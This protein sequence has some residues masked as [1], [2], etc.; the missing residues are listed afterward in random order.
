M[1]PPLQFD[2]L[3]PHPYLAQ[4]LTY[5]SWLFGFFFFFLNHFLPFSNQ[6][7]KTKINPPKCLQ[8][9]PTSKT[10]SHV[11]LLFL[12]FQIFTTTA[13]QHFC[14]HNHFSLLY[15][16]RLLSTSTLILMGFILFCLWTKVSTFNKILVNGY[17][18]K[19]YFVLVYKDEFG[20]NWV[21]RKELLRFFHVGVLG[22]AWNLNNLFILYWVANG[23]CILPFLN[24]FWGGLHS[25]WNS[26]LA[27]GYVHFYCVVGSTSLRDTQV[28]SNLLTSISWILWLFLENW[29]WF[30][31]CCIC[32]FLKW[33]DYVRILKLKQWTWEGGW[34][35]KVGLSLHCLMAFPMETCLWVSYPSFFFLGL[36]VLVLLDI[37]W[38]LYGWFGWPI[39][40]NGNAGWNRGT[41]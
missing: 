17:R 10:K 4:K 34:L 23:Y 24:L 5:T 27:N 21:I 35:W 37:F 22:R 20:I 32:W 15:S 12:S 29:D 13:C 30:F 11:F 28:C 6:P 19:V 38:V 25:S 3:F 33:R 41:I 1:E 18:K 14:C 31:L 36:W 16:K 26:L 2:Y 39:S 9:S 40:G 7:I 8:K